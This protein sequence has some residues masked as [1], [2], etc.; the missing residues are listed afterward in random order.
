MRE[1]PVP[2]RTAS[3]Y[4]LPPDGSPRRR[5]PPRF[6]HADSPVVRRRHRRRSRRPDRRVR[7]AARDARASARGGGVRR[8]RRDLAHRELSRVPHGPGRSSLLLALRLGDGLVAV[9]AAD[10]SR[11][12]GGRRGA[13]TGATGSDGRTSSCRRIGTPRPT[14]TACCSCGGGCRASTHRRRFFDYPIRLDLKTVLNLGIGR[15]IAAELSYVRAHAFP[16]EPER[17]LEDFLIN[18]FGRRALPRRSSSRTPRRCGA[19]PAPASARPG[20]RSGSRACRSSARCST[21]CSARWAARRRTRRASLIERFLYP[22]L[23]PGQM[24]EEAARP[25]A[26]RRRDAGDEHA[27]ST[28][29]ACTT[30]GVRRGGRAPTADGASRRYPATTSSRRCRCKDLVACI[31]PPPPAAVREVAA[32]LPYRDFITVGPA[33]AAHV[34]RRRHERAAARGCRPTT[35]STSRSRT[36]RLGRL[37]IFNNWSP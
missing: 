25:R 30:A 14:P 4:S 28:R 21:P 33:R 3:L 16:R 6:P 37:Q 17:N 5:A 2:R 20:A 8:R 11:G 22:K 29:R 27:A 31:D 13:A 34:D 12:R 9:D 19:C 35:G 7:A 18:R 15:S 23:G 32:R 36:C 10:R 26:G 24:W 1:P